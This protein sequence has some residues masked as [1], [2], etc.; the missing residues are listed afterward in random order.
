MRS[1]AL[2][3]HI[4]G[5]AYGC[6]RMLIGAISVAYLMRAGLSL[7]QIGL[8]KSFQAAVIVFIDIPLSY[9]PITTVENFPSH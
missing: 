1:P 5:I 9:F 8:L 3:V 2:T 4:V 6:V 7:P